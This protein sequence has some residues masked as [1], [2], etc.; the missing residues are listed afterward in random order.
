MTYQTIEINRDLWQVLLNGEPVGQVR[1]GIDMQWYP[2]LL[3]SEGFR[4]AAIQR[5]ILAHEAMTEFMEG[6]NG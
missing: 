2:E 3:P 5:V 1:R 4:S 6:V